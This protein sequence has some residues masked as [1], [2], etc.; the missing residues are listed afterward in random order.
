MTRTQA[1]HGARH[2]R[3]GLRRPSASGAL[4]CRRSTTALAAAT[5][6]HRS[7]P[8]HALPGTVLVRNG[9]Y[10]LPAAPVQRV[11]PRGPVIV[12]AGRFGPEPPGSGGDETPP[13]GPVLAPAVRHHR[14]ASF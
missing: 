3:C 14:P 1:A 10:P 11:L 4:A 2:G 6:R 12:P 5:E 13:A 7:A 9:R 8:V